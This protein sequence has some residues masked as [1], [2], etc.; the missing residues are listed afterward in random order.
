MMDLD[1]RAET[2]KFLIRDRDA[3]FV[4]AFNAVFQCTGIQGDQD[5]GPGAGGRTRSWSGGSVPAEG[6]FSIGPSP[7]TC[8][9]YGESWPG[10]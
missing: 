2:I 3:K 5:P 8:R 6:R 4:A 1:G 9:T 10:T 7:G